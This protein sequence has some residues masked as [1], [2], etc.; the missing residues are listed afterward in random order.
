VPLLRE[1]QQIKNRAEVVRGRVFENKARVLSV[2][3]NSHAF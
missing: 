3:Q 2:D 1:H